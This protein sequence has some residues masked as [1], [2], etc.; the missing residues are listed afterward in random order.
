MKNLDSTFLQVIERVGHLFRQA[1]TAFEGDAFQGGYGGRCSRRRT[2]ER[3]SLLEPNK[4]SK[5]KIE[6][7]DF[8]LNAN[9]VLGKPSSLDMSLQ[10]SVTIRPQRLITNA[11]CPGFVSFL[12]I[13]VANMN[14]TVGSNTDAYSYSASAVGSSLDCPTISPAN[15][16]TIAGVYSGVGMN[17]EV[18][19]PPLGMVRRVTGKLWVPTPVVSVPKK[20]KKSS[21]RSRTT[22]PPAQVVLIE[23][24]LPEDSHTSFGINFLFVATFQGP[25]TIVA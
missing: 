21:R 1:K 2:E 5:T 14:V 12:I 7:Y 11:P 15:R 17:G 23:L 20:T 24:E 22:S 19:S 3:E 16:V 6:R 10:P 25:A 9:L 4:G 13:Q 18:L 8:S